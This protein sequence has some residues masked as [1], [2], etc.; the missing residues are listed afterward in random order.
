MLTFLEILLML[1]G[2]IALIG[3]GIWGLIEVEKTDSL[4]WSLVL[5]LL[6]MIDIG[7]GITAIAA[8]FIL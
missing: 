4:V 2:G 7:I 6:A 5:F 8:L 3:V 1:L